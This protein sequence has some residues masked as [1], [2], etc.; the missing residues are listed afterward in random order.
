MEQQDAREA[1]YHDLPEGTGEADP[2]AY[3][4]A[5]G[6]DIVSFSKGMF[7]YWTEAPFAAPFR[8]MLTVEQYRSPTMAG[9]HRQYLA[10]GPMGYVTDLFRG[11]VLSDPDRRAAAFLGP[12]FLLCSVYDGVEDKATGRPCWVN[13]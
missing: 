2:A 1:R 4:T 10:A 11:L 12:L 8:R 3:E 7:R 6:E 9:H 13:I 5:S